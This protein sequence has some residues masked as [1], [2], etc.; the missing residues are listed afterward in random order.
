[1]L[2]SLKKSK[3]KAN[4]YIN[5]YIHIYVSTYTLLLSINP[6]EKKLVY[7]NIL[8]YTCLFWHYY[9]VKKW[10]QPTY[11]SRHK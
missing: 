7:T 3:K 8:V 4:L 2:R 5:T 6:K 9:I 11:P 10:N 1:M